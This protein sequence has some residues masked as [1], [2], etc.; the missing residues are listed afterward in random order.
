[1]SMLTKRAIAATPVAARTTKLAFLLV[2]NVFVLFAGAIGAEAVGGRVAEAT[3][4]H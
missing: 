2:F 4:G 1:M 3:F